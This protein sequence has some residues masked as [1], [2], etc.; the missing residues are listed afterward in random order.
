[1]LAAEAASFSCAV[2]AFVAAGSPRM[3]TTPADILTL[4]TVLD[5]TAC[6]STSIS[7]AAR[8]LFNVRHYETPP[9]V[10]GASITAVL[11]SWIRRASLSHKREADVTELTGQMAQVKTDA[12]TRAASI[13][14]ERDAPGSLVASS[15]HAHHLSSDRPRAHGKS[16]RSSSSCSSRERRRRRKEHKKRKS[17]RRSRSHSHSLDHDRERYYYISRA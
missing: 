4:Q 5:L 1:M 7:A 16:E 6:P 13:R 10:Q 14:H 3:S 8:A 9:L 11:A 2:S 17:R 15:G 12:E